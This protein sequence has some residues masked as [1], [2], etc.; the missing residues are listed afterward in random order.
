MTTLENRPN[1]AVLVID[2]QNGVVGG[3]YERDAVVANVGAVVDKARAAEVPVLWVRHSERQPRRGKRALAVRRRAEP[4]RE[5]S[6]SSRSGIRDSFEETDARVAPCRPRRRPSRRGRRADGRVRSLDAARRARARLRRDAR[7]RRAHDGGP[8][9]GR[10]RRR[11][12]HRAHNLDG[13]TRPRP[14]GRTS[15]RRTS[16]SPRPDEHAA[17]RGVHQALVPGRS[18]GPVFS[19]VSP[20]RIA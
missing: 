7:E 15:R 13:G 5:P 11:T 9:R 14:D 6:R 17:F 3:A 1:T 10:R 2:V 4:G 18:P 8:D 20:E 16:T 19:R 12:R